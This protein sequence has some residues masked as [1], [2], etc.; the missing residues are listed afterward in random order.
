MKD[1]SERTVMMTALLDR[2]VRTEGC[3]YVSKSACNVYKTMLEKGI[4]MI[5]AA[6]VL[7]ALV[8]DIGRRRKDDIKEQVTTSLL[9]GGE[10]AELICGVFSPLYDEESLSVMK[11]EE[12]AGINGFCSSEHEVDGIEL[13]SDDCDHMKSG[14]YY[15]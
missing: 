2:S 12:Y 11:G 6:S 10:C 5:D 3:E 9:L 13:I 7:Y 1:S 4:D 8:S 14:F 15:I